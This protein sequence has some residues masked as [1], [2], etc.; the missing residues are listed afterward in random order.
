MNRAWPDH[1]GKSYPGGYTIEDE[2][3]EQHGDGKLVYLQKIGSGMMADWSIS[4]HT[5]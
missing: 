5:T 4:S 2:I 3:I 1:I